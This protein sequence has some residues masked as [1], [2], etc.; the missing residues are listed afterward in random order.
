MAATESIKLHPNTKDLSGKRFGKLKVI[1]VSHS[2]KCVNRRGTVLY[3]RCL[4][5]CGTECVIPAPSLNSGDASSCGCYRNERLREASLLH[6]LASSCE[7]DIWNMMKQR[8]QNP[9]NAAFDIYGGRGISV[10]ADWS[11]SFEMFYRDMGPRP[12]P[13]H[14]LDRIDNDG[15]Y[16]PGNVQWATRKQQ[17][18]NRRT[19][20]IV[21]HDGR[22]MSLGELSDLT[23]IS[24]SKLWQRRKHGGALVREKDKC[25]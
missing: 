18:R 9:N 5:D 2:R 22:L 20:V 24:Y 17:S 6:G 1:C 4:C 19:T 14:S 11:N 15:N 21:E 23:G 16:E 10:C 3:W 7:F 25:V 13:D 8:C 12:S